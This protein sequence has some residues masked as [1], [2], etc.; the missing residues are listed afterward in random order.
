MFR[1]HSV[2]AAR[3][4]ALIQTKSPTNCSIHL[5]E[6][7]FQTRSREK[8]GCRDRKWGDWSE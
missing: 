4:A 1:L 8:D 2:D 3:C 6:S 5:A 7:I